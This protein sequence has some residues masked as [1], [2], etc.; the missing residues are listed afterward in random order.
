DDVVV[1]EISSFQ[2][3]YLHVDR[4]SPHVAIV[5]NL[6]PNH[7]DRHKTM[8]NYRAVKQH[9]VEHQSAADFAV[10]NADDE[11]VLSMAQATHARPVLFSVRSPVREGAWLADNAVHCRLDGSESVI[12]G[13]DRLRIRGHHNLQNVCAAAAAAAVMGVDAATIEDALPRFEPLPHRL[14]KVAERAGVDYFDD[15]IATNPDSVAAALS[16]FGGDVVLVAGGSPKDVPWDDMIAPVVHKVKLLVLIG[17]TAGAIEEAVRSVSAETPEIV[18]AG[19]LERAVEVAHD[20]A[21]TGD[22]VLLS[23]G[24]A[25]FDQFRNFRE[26]GKRFQDLVLALPK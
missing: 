17:E 10:L 14:Q 20:R 21:R 12:R 16:C 5:L 18:R 1:L 15:S 13:L 19:T 23:P 8:E 7:L 3:E 4:V 11:A 6:R 26:R 24:C 25:S 9:I 2:L 22:V